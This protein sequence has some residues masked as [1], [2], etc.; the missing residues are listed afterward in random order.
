MVCGSNI[1]QLTSRD[2]NYKQL[3]QKYTAIYFWKR[4]IKK[5]I[6]RFLVCL[7]TENILHNIVCHKNKIYDC[8]LA[9]LTQNNKPLQ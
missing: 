6:Q 4:L 5:I 3:F 8:E 1:E 9:F 7:N 2:M